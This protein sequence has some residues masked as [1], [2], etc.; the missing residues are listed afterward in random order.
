[1]AKIRELKDLASESEEFS[2]EDFS[3]GN[4]EEE[5]SQGKKKGNAAAAASASAA[6]SSAACSP[7]QILV[8]IFIAIVVRLRALLDCK[9]HVEPFAYL[10][11]FGAAILFARPLPPRTQVIGGMFVGSDDATTYAP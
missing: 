8:L 10:A 6:G 5:D 4:S 3:E 1:M 2:D 11:I 7:L 9:Y